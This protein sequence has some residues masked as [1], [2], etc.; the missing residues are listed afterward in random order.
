MDPPKLAFMGL[1]M[2][3]SHINGTKA[4]P[5]FGKSLF[6]VVVGIFMELNVGLK[7]PISASFQN[8]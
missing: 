8:E 4:N 2:N 1:M 3:Q 5:W 6:G 7:W